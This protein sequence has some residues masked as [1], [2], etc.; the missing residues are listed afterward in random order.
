MKEV[1]IY[2]RAERAESIVFAVAGIVAVALSVWLW[3][4]I[5]KPF[6]NGMATTLSAIAIIHM[7][8]GLTI[9]F[10]TPADIDRVESYIALEQSKIQSEELPRM[11]KVMKNFVFLRY[12]EI[13]LATVAIILILY[14]KSPGYWKGFGAGLFAQALLSLMLDFFAEN[15][16]R[17]YIDYLKTFVPGNEA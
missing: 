6:Y 10:R 4:S 11:E 14:F 17:I 1:L 16:G 8:I 15:R 5:R 2:F 3:Y 13:V 7:V 9:Y 12:T